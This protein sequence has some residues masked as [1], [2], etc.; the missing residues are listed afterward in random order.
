M[1]IPLPLSEYLKKTRL[2]P[3]ARPQLFIESEPGPDLFARLVQY[4]GQFC[5]EVSL[6]Y[7]QAENT[8]EECNRL[9]GQLKGFFLRKEACGTGVRAYFSTQP[10]ALRLI[11]GA[12]PC[13]GDWKRPRLPENPT[14]WTPS[15]KPAFLASTGGKNAPGA[16]ID[17]NALDPEQSRILG[18]LE[19]IR[20]DYRVLAEEQAQ[21]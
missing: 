6:D 3:R 20:L 18:F 19:L 1:E 9:L 8:G 5:P 11:L 17:T 7:F 2:L 16:L 12:G 4:L 14:F 10:A 13:L 21:S 15:G